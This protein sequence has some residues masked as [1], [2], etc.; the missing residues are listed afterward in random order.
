MDLD[1]VADGVL[2]GSLFHN[3]LGKMIKVVIDKA[4]PFLEERL[5][6]KVELTAVSSSEI[7]KELVGDADALIVR[8]RTRCDASLLEGSGV[9]FVASATAGDDHIDRE[10]CETA[11]IEVCVASG[12]NAPGVAQYTLASLLRSRF[13]PTTDTLGIVGKG[14]VGSIVASWARQLGISVVVSDP[15][16]AQTGFADEDYLSLEEVLQRSRAVTFHVPLTSEGN[17]PTLRMLD[18]GNVGLLRPDAVV[19]NAARGGVIDEKA[20][21]SRLRQSGQ[22]VVDTWENEPEISLGTLPEA[23]V[24]T[25]HIAGYSLEGKQRGTSMVIEGLNR[26]FGLDIDTKGLA[27]RFDDKG[28]ITASKILY[29][30]DPFEDTKLLKANPE[31][32]ENLRNHYNYR[33]EPS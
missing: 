13:D 2:Y 25:P 21:L 14:N 24:A 5:S 28:D 23:F 10:W 11:G 32:F 3:A 29:S 27:G 8:T 19:I 26:R 4:I 31:G 20:V 17:Y 18:S 1:A 30:Y 6:G 12:C 16:R 22:L 15:L 7:T 9:R 33:R